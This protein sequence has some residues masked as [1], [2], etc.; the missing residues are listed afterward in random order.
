M[1]HL[2]EPCIVLNYSTG[3]NVC[4]CEESRIT[5]FYYNSIFILLSNGYGEHWNLKGLQFISI[6]GM[7]S[8]LRLYSFNKGLEDKNYQVDTN[9]KVQRMHIA[10]WDW[11]K[12]GSLQPLDFSHMLIHSF[13]FFQLIIYSC[14][15]R[16]LSLL[17]IPR[18]NQWA[19]EKGI[20]CSLRN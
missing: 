11:N 19:H 3:I 7:W 4:I 9:R 13:S 18:S 17:S 8:T 5:F 10:L 6:F 14:N 1:T 16:L 20:L 12:S 15:K 2:H